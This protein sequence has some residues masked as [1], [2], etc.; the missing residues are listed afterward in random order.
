MSAYKF[1]NTSRQKSQKERL[2]FRSFYA[3][4]FLAFLVLAASLMLPLFPLRLQLEWLPECQ[5]LVSFECY[6]NFREC[7]KYSAVLK[8]SVFLSSTVTPKS[9][10]ATVLAYH[11]AHFGAPAKKLLWACY[12]QS[13][14]SS[15][16]V[17]ETEA[18]RFVLYIA[19][20]TCDLPFCPSTLPAVR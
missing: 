16:L 10:Q 4:P 1:R 20:R 14:E 19:V 12:R 5:T 17:Y 2:L 15:Q 13:I 6:L 18:V 3:R 11:A 7:E 8:R 9:R